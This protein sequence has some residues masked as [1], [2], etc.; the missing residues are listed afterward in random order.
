MLQKLTDVATNIN[1]STAENG[2]IGANFI[3]KMT[4]QLI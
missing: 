3:Q 4:D 1:V 2:F